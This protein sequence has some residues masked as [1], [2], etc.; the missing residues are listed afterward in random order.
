[1]TTRHE[2]IEKLKDMLD[3]FETELD[4]FEARAQ[5]TRVDLKF[6]LD[7][8]ISLLKA[9]RE[10]AKSKLSEIMDSGEEAWQDIKH[11]ADEA[12]AALKQ[13][14]DKARSHF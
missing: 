11:G 14:M 10:V 13:A 5:K 12:W 8:Q 9:R 4:E 2:Y 6:E 1:M 7:D 3:E